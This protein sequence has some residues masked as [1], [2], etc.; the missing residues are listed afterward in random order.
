MKIALCQINTIVGDFAAN[1]SKISENYRQAMDR[2]ADL[3]VFPE[4]AICGYPPLDLIH[5]G[6]FIASNKRYLRRLT[7]ETTVPLIIGTL[8]KTGEKIY[9]RAV[10]L[11]DG[12]EQ[13]NYDKLLLPTYDVFDE[14]RYF[15]N[16]QAPRV[17]DITAGGQ[18]RRIGIEICEDLWDDDYPLK[19][20]SQLQKAGAEL[21]INISASPYH[22]GRLPERLALIR[23]KVGETRI[24][25]Y[26]CNLVG[27]Q[28][29]L[30]FDGQS[31]AVDWDGNLIGMGAAFDED[32]II[33]DTEAP[34]TAQPVSMEREEE[35]FRGLCLGV[36]DYIRKVGYREVIIGMS[37]GIDSTLVAAIAAEAL[38]AEHVHGFALPSKYSSDHSVDDARAL[39]ENL[40]IDFQ[41]I[42]IQ[43]IVDALEGNLPDLAK[44]PADITEENNQARIRGNIL[45]AYSNKMNWLVLSCGNKTELALGY[46]T[47]YGDM[48]GGLAVI[49]DLSKTDVYN[50][51]R[52]YNR[53]AGRVIIP[54]NCINKPPSAELKPGQVDPFDYDLVSPLV[55]KIVEDR[56]SPRELINGGY[57]A[58]LVLDLYHKIHRN[59]YKRRQAA[60]GLR[61]SPKAFGSGRRIPIVNHY[62]GINTEDFE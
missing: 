6:D 30:I 23:S 56:L 45:M 1:H 59:E 44:L 34:Q 31:L 3:V 41:V 7:D 53:Q 28:D 58:E 25:F 24:P 35:I 10:F 13:F 20:T 4:L 11:S 9:N 39:A 40:G 2:G 19:V 32:L 29:E 16:G 5:E 42:P 26:Y 17:W 52:W 46:C 62:N 57:P 8:H 51:A 38:G 27:G 33:V 48:V 55:D 14:N 15:T 12:R 22:E 37:G 54:E 47:L 43:P 61:V 21:I 18:T 60:P 36:R 49:S 50:L